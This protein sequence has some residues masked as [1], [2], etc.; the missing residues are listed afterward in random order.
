MSRKIQAAFFDMGGTIETFNFT[1]A[2]RLEATAVIQQRLYQVGI[3]LRLR[4]EQLLAVI[5]KGLER[6]KSWSVQTLDELPP[7]RVWS[8]YIFPEQDVELDRLAPIAEELSFLVETRFYCRTM[9]PE[10]PAVL[11]A[12]QQMGLKIGLISNVN[13]RGQVLANLEQYGIIHYFNPIVLSSTYGRRKPDPAIF[14]YAARLANAPASECVYVGDRINRDI[15]GAQRAGFRLAVQIRHN[16]EQGEIDEGAI[17]DVVINNMTELVEVLHAEI[18][19]TSASK[20]T[21]LIQAILFDAG[22]ILYHR[23]HRGRQFNTFLRKLALNPDNPHI[24]EK[25]EL[26][27]QAYQGQIS[28]DDYREAIV[29]LYGVTQPELIERGKQIIGTEDNNVLFFS[30]VRETLVALKEM[31]Y[32]L[33]IVTDT[34][35]PVYVKLRWF[36]KGG[37]GM[38]WD[39]IISSK[40]LGVRKPDPR[41]YQAALR[42]LGLTADQAIFVGHKATEL[43][44]ARAVGL[45]TVAFNYE[46][47]AKADFYIEKFADLRKVH[48]LVSPPTVSR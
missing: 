22:D 32:L 47:S 12:I 15:L 18:T 48:L 43:D 16:F 39:S 21:S 34:A 17:P 27:N 24:A 10:M 1:H 20:P 3:D 31:G 28:Q 29:R 46:K 6:Y 9:R 35:S 42:Q 44:G 13:S 33:G 2:L 41:L 7:L 11:E 40:E 19:H 14:H 45:K 23:P 8:E 37:F 36:E 26:A 30:G 38:V 4:D 25:E 5:T